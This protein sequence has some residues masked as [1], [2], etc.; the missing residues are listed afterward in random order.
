[1]EIDNF[2]S[3]TS[4]ATEKLPISEFFTENSLSQE[5]MEIEIFGLNFG[6]I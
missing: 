2:T 1:M 6:P 4:D 3:I 5:Q